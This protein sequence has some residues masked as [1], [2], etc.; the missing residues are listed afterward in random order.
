MSGSMVERYVCL[1]RGREKGPG[2][3]SREA[4]SEG[5]GGW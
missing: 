4:G 2:M 5:L 1:R 3:N